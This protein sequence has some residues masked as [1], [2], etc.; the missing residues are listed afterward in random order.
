MDLETFLEKDMMEFLEEKDFERKEKSSI[1]NEEE[2]EREYTDQ[3]LIDE[4]GIFEKNSA[5]KMAIK[6]D[7][8]KSSEIIFEL[9][10][11]KKVF[12]AIQ[13]Y[14]KMKERFNEFPEDAAKEKEK[15]FT[16][17][18]VNY[19]EIR[20]VEKAM[21]NKQMVIQNNKIQKQNTIQNNAKN[22]IIIR[23]KKIRAFLKESNI[24]NAMK[25]YEL[26]KQE[27]ESFP[28]D[29]LE[30]KKNLYNLISNIYKE[31]GEAIN[32]EKK[33]KTTTNQPN[34]KVETLSSETA[35][36]PKDKLLSEKEVNPVEDIKKNI[37][38]IILLMK[39]QRITDAEMKLLE[40]KQQI[41]Q[42]PTDKDVESSRFEHLL[43]E[44]THRINFL[45]QTTEMNN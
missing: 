36:A 25:E 4:P 12:D 18:I 42:L 27:F 34:T 43:E 5:L 11:Y 40:V 16:E 10:K 24:N 17:V 44:I 8:T 15:L 26:A 9:L 41:N 31:I 28:N 19:Y 7:V 32:S 2:T 33:E 45:K 38:E 13:E 37:K 1:I 35:G 3:P 20:K 22:S 6:K 39:Q 29:S 21:K 30:E 14:K 23:T